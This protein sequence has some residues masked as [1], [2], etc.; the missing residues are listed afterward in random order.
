[1]V[2]VADWCMILLPSG[3]CIGLHD[4]CNGVSWSEPHTHCSEQRFLS[5]S[6]VILSM[7]TVADWC[8]ILLPSGV[9]I[10]LHDKCNGVSWS[11]PHT[12][13]SEQRFLSVYVYI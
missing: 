2:T 10:G 9:C 3:V 5:V 13:C 7:V 12:H 11:E 4:K 6:K 1:M 8:M